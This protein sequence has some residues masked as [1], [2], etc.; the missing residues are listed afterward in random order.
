MTDPI[1]LTVG[2]EQ[3]D[4][5]KFGKLLESLRERAGL[6]R[7]AASQAIDITSEYLRLIERG[8]R[9]PS[10]GLMPGILD[11]Y[12]IESFS[13]S[14]SILKFDEYAIEFV[15]RIKEKRNAGSSEL[16]TNRNE[17]IGQIVSLL[18][19]SDDATLRS[20]HKKL[21]EARN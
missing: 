16:L 4:N 21:L 13:I 7:A 6:S 1:R 14:Y 3:S 15:S 8:K 20:I 17:R 12:G 2:P 10:L 5:E 19:I 18:T 11:F 9:V